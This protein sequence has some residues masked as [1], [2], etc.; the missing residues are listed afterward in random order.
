MQ[1]KNNILLAFCRTWRLSSLQCQTAGDYNCAHYLIL[2]SRTIHPIVVL[3]TGK[4][5]E[6]NVKSHNRRF[7]FKEI[8]VVSRRLLAFSR[9][10]L[11]F[12]GNPWRVLNWEASSIC[13]LKSPF[14]S[15][16]K[17]KQDFQYRSL[18]KSCVCKDCF[19]LLFLNLGKTAGKFFLKSEWGRA[20]REPK[21]FFLLLPFLKSSDLECSFPRK[22]LASME[23]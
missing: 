4:E 5:A 21:E 8:Y 18:P 6:F 22:L 9:W 7:I 11:K 10:Q 13:H 15:T 19:L 3:G 14:K 16:L 23:H 12:A 20:R 17:D 1:K 2:S